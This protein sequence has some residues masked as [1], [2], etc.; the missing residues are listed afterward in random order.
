MVIGYPGQDA[1]PMCIV[2]SQ[3]QTVSWIINDMGPYEVS[4]LCNGTLTG[5]IH[6]SH[7]TMLYDQYTPYT[8]QL[9]TK[10]T[11]TL[12][13]SGVPRHISRITHGLFLNARV[14][15]RTY[16]Y[17]MHVSSARK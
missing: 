4:T 14:L 10:F 1:E 7:L 2:T 11:K 6:F 8:V 5:L 16:K 17:L 9:T 15:Q 13:S 12:V 3:S